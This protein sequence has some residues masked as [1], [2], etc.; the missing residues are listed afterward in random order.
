MKS[1]K[2]LIRI[3]R[4]QLDDLRR[5]MANFEAQRDRLIQGIQAL[6]AELE[7]EIQ[8]AEEMVGLGNFFGNFAG[9]IRN[10]QE[11]LG[12]EVKKLDIEIIKLSQK[13]AAIFS[14][15]KKYEIALENRIKAMK[16]EENRKETQMLDEVGL[17]QF[18]RKNAENVTE[19]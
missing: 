2:T 11:V 18:R 1:L 12:Q 17:Q 10:R 14:E 8:L 3:H 19:S 9:R 15:V 6:Q 16:A 4:R 7:R 5:E 13:I